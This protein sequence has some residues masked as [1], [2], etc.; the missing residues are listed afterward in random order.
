MEVISL[1][2]NKKNTNV[3]EGQSQKNVNFI[4]IFNKVIFLKIFM[5][6]THFHFAG[7]YIDVFLLSDIDIILTYQK[8]FYPFKNIKIFQISEYQILKFPIISK[9]ILIPFI[10]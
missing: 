7:V 10:R 4:N 1:S 6:L 5:K 3:E 8:Y 9:S 2:H